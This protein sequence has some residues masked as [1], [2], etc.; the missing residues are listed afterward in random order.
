MSGKNKFEEQYY[1]PAHEA[2]F[3]GVRNF[4]RVNAQGGY[5]SN[6]EKLIA[7]L[8]EQDTYTLHRHRFACSL[9]STQERHLL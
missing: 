4:L 2:G 3:A 9:G 7:W 6:R 1:D 8:D 5:L